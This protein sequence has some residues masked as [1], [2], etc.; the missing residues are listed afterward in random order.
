MGKA[1]FSP[2]FHRPLFQK[3]GLVTNRTFETFCADTV[4]ILM[5]PGDT[6]REIYGESALPLAPGE[7]LC[8]RLGDMMH[9]PEVYWE[10]V[11]KTRAHLAEHHSYE[12]RF[13]ELVKILNA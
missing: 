1:K 7:Q 13:A 2:V 9:R 5:L 8:D 3:L 11:L 12:R 6:V 4:P 10:A